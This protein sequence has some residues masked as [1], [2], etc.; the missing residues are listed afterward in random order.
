MNF[1]RFPA[2]QGQPGLTHAVN[3]SYTVGDRPERVRENL[4]RVK[5]FLGAEKLLFMDQ[6]HGD[7]IVVF[8]ARMDGA[9]GP[10]PPRADALITD[11]PG[12]ALLV[13][14]ADCQAVILYDPEKRVAANV[15]CGWRGNVCNVLG[16]VVERMVREFGCRAERLRAAIGP[17]LGPCCGEFR[18]YGKLFPSAFLRYRVDDCRFDLWSVSCSQLMEAG[19]EPS[20]MEVACIC[21]RCRTDFFFSYRAEG[22]TGRF[23]TVVMLN[24]G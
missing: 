5:R 15:H 14:Q 7:G 10:P 4:D 17:S 8:R 3:L 6:C 12:A 1:F 18:D 9:L 2:L 19:L 16:R 24:S 22:R 20:H 23:G 11:V 21:T 13:K